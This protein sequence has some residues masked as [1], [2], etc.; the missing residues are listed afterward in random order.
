MTLTRRVNEWAKPVL[1][2]KRTM[3]R[4]TADRFAAQVDDILQRMETGFADVHVAFCGLFS[5][6]K[7]SLINALVSSAEL[8]TGAV[9]TTAEVAAVRLETTAGSVILLDTPGVDSTD[10]AHQAAMEAA[11]HKADLV[12]L[13]MDYQHVESEE[14]MAL[15][16]Y[17]LDRGKRL[18][19]V[20]NQVDKH[21]DWE[22]PFDEFKERVER[23]FSD[24]GIEYEEIFYTSTKSS[25]HSMFVDFRKW[26]ERLA[27]D[28]ERIAEQSALA[29]LTDIV[30]RF[31][32]ERYQGELEATES[33]LIEQIGF[34]PFDEA[35]AAAWRD[36]RKARLD[37]LL[38]QL[39]AEDDRIQ[40]EAQRLEEDLRRTVE[41]AQ[42]SPYETTELGRM[43]VESLRPGFKVG[44]IG[45]KQKTAA[46][47]ERRLHAFAGE[48]QSRAE[49]F[50]VWPVHGKLREWL[51]K[52]EWARPEWREQIDNVS[53]SVTADLCRSLVHQGAI[54]SDQYPYQ[55]VKDVVASVKGQVMAR[56]RGI[57]E[58]WFQAEKALR[59]AA[60]E[61]VFA[62]RDAISSELQTLSAWL[63]LRA[64][65]RQMVEDLL[66]PVLEAFS[67]AAEGR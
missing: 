34:V 24:Y 52:T 28:G 14:N 55:Y 63:N 12:V 48:L 46:E 59:R 42:I 49:K 10:E 50:M 16:R 5:A 41:L 6:G 54:L 60:N 65:R 36:E 20:V 39:A 19:L 43:Y 40:A 56:I 38:A 1:E 37:A 8:A 35:E 45:A 58:Q 33:Q 2:L 13:V 25:P 51:D 66:Q 11:L 27:A 18:C 17:L 15:A 31:V 53:V 4:F 44:W 9:P 26:L 23:A 67:E 3:E 7:S 30:Q 32:S 47:Q 22:L 64:G 61:E 29:N 62:E 57:L 21:V